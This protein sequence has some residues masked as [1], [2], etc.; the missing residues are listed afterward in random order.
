MGLLLALSL[1]VCVCEF[2]LFLDRFPSLIEFGPF[3]PRE[4]GDLDIT[5]CVQS[6]N[7]NP[8][9]STF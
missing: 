7:S 8:L 5:A 6:S 2:E 4:V 1:E 9:I 3:F